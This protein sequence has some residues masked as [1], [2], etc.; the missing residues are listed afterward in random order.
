ML[1][2]VPRTEGSKGYIKGLIW[3]ILSGGLWTIL[4]LESTAEEDENLTAKIKYETKWLLKKIHTRT[5]TMILQNISNT[6]MIN[7]IKLI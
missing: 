7:I 1:P 3:T 6:S 4:Q 2:R 5:C